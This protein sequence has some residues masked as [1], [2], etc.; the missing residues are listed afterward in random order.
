MAQLI[1]EIFNS[2]RIYEE[3][4]GT[5]T[6]DTPI[7]IESGFTSYEDAYDYGSDI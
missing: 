7:H 1:K 6:V 4:D 3:A 5:F 2:T